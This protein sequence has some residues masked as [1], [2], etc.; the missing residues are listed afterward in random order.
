MSALIPNLHVAGYF[1]VIYLLAVVAG[2]FIQ[3]QDLSW[4]SRLEAWL[5]TLTAVSATNYVVLLEPFGFRM[6]ALIA[7][8][9]AGMKTVVTLEDNGQERCNISF[10]WWLIFNLGWVGPR[11]KV[12]TEPFVAY[13]KETESLALRGL[14]W[15]SV[16]GALFYL[17]MLV[18]SGAVY[19]SFVSRDLLF[20]FLALPALSLIFHFGLLNLLAAF[21]QSNRVGC[22]SQFNE[23][24][25]ATSLSSFWGKRWNNAFSEMATSAIYRPLSPIVGTNLAAMAVFIFSGA[26]HELVISFPV[27]AG[28]GLPMLYFLIHGC[29]VVTERKFKTWGYSVN[30]Y[31]VIGWIWTAFW[32]ILPLPILFHQPF[33]KRIIWPIFNMF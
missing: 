32:L 16:G 21:W 7:A 20:F 12:F 19:V 31:P 11:A 10:G 3:K 13:R 4:K 26:L 9:F 18:G 5:L 33:I 23:P 24:F 28:Y 22:Q 27:H 15:A 29:L 30:T 17:A 14:L 2:Y 25:L 6:L 8:L 1:L